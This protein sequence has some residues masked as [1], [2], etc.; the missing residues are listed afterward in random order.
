MPLLLIGL[1]VVN[2]GV[3]SWFLSPPSP[4]MLR[5]DL[6]VY[7]LGAQ[8]WLAG[9]DLYGRLPA[10]LIGNHLPFTYPPVSAV[11][12]TPFTL[13]SHQAGSF[14]LTL[15]SIVVLAFVLVV[16]ARSQAV[17]PVF[18]LVGAFLP[19]ALALEPV[20]VTLYFG[21]INVLLMGLVAADCLVRGPKWPRGVLVGLA[22]A[23]KLTPAA[24]V[25]FFL[26]RGDR[27]AALTA[28]VSF[29]CVTAAGFV[30]NWRGSVRYWTSTLFD[31]GRIGKVSHESNLSLAGV[32]ARLGGERGVLWLALV[33]AVVAVGVLAVRRALDPVVALGLNGFVVLLVSPVSWSH[34]W[35]WAVP[36]L[37]ATGVAA[38][39]HRSRVPAAFTAGG[40]VLFL[41]SPHWWYEADDGTTVAGFVVGN[42]YAWC[43]LGVL[44]W[45]AFRSA[46]RQL[47]RAGVHVD[48]RAV[49]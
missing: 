10:T 46:D 2:A 9:G 27:R 16:M 23:V 49:A 45:W 24:F 3:L 43:A 26:L 8:V 21:Q 20:R 22:A 15:A 37:F 34:H 13:L 17:R 5:I 39:R 28:V 7:R 30:L 12:F 32:L 31:P 41:V 29:A 1:L 38:W 6:D 35:V 48:H 18:V 44:A 36:L 25:L 4:A 40:V 19:L 14:V 11:L 47:G 33:C 42:A